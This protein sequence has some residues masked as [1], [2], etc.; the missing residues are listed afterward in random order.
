MDRASAPWAFARGE[1][2]RAIASLELFGTLLGLM[3]LIDE[4]NNTDDY[5]ACA[6]SV[7]GITDNNGTGTLSQKC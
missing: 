5:F 6:L 7:G 1:P 2:F 4:A 3:L